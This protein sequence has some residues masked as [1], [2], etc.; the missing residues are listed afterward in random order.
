[1]N[2]STKHTL[3]LFVFAAAIAARPCPGA[4]LHVDGASGDDAASG[5]APATALRSIQKACD[6]VKPGDVVVVKPGVYFEHVQLRTSG[7][8]DKPITFRTD[9]VAKNRVVL[10]GAVPAVRQGKVPWRLDDPQLQLYS[11]ALPHKPARVLYDGVDLLP[12]PSLDGLKRFRLPQPAAYPGTFHGFA[13]DPAA[14]RLW[15]R[16][17]ASGRYGSPDPNRHTMSVAPPNGRGSAGNQITEPHHYNF[18]ILTDKP[19]HVVLDGF[20]FETPGVAGVFV[21]ANHATIRNS[22]FVGCRTGVSG[23]GDTPDESRMSHN[24]VIEYCDYSQFP[25]F[26][27]MKEVIDRYR[28]DPATLDK[29]LAG[30]IY[31][32]QRKGYSPDGMIGYTNTYEIGIAARIGTD[33]VVRHNH[34]HDALEGLS[35]WSVRWS[36]RLQV[37]DNVFERLIDN[38]V[39][40]EDHA[41]DMTVR[42]NLMV[43]VFEP[44]SWQPLGGTP[45]PGPIHVFRNVIWTTEPHRGLWKRAGWFPGV[46]KLGVMNRNAELAHMKKVP[47]TP[48]QAP[49]TGFQVWNNTVFCPGSRVFTRV[50]GL[51]RFA[52]FGFANNLVVADELIK[53]PGFKGGGIHFASNLVLLSAQNQKVHGG[54]FAGGKGKNLDR[55]EEAGLADPLKGHFELLNHSPARNAAAA[56]PFAPKPPT[57]IGAVQHGQTWKPPIAGPRT[58]TISLMK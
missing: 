20:T 40:T 2:N 35:T 22:W 43:D 30:T 19:A 7:T 9:G 25:A 41:A 56:V 51:W 6:R 33:W 11:I 52:N 54:L 46:F 42:D 50:G 44:I 45:W 12:Y 21:R 31:W 37:H 39:E 53:D 47:L 48:T 27:D 38:A 13:H 5:L 28:N 18:G 16:L 14:G 17:H 10:S 36:K 8:P 34:I 49:G 26:D 57:D 4:T 23:R 55:L 1:M 24:V 3:V 15:V 29:N 58:A 32:W